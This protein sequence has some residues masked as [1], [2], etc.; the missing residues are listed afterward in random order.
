M[1]GARNASGVALKGTPAGVLRDV[2]NR[3]DSTGRENGPGAEPFLLAAVRR[4][5][6]WASN[7][8]DARMLIFSLLE[9][10]K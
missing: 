7:S 2:K 8:V 3:G 1:D 10:E 6:P 5:Q 4:N 9:L